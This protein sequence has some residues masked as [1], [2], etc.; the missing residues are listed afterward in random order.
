M[1]LGPCSEEEVPDGGGT[2]AGSG[3]WVCLACSL[4]LT[5]S[6]PLSGPSSHLLHETPPFYRV[7]IRNHLCEAFPGPTSL[8]AVPA[9]RC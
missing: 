9:L 6:L 4:N 2:V 3:P 8:G 1:G 5:F 7:Q